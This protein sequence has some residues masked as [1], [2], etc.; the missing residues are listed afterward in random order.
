MDSVLDRIHTPMDLHGLSIFELEFLAKELR[1][2]IIETVSKNGGHLAPNL[3]TIE[4]TLALYSVFSLPEDKVVWDVGHQAY[5]HKILTG[6]RNRFATLRK[7]GGITGF[8]NIRESDY[9]SFGVGHASTSI[10]AALGLAVARDL[11][12][13]D[14]HIIAVIGDGALTGGEAYEALNHAGALKIPLIVIVNDNHMSIDA[15]VGAMNEYLTRIRLAPEYRKAKRDMTSLLRSIPHI[16]DTVY[17]TASHIK[18]GVRAALVAGNLFEE[19]GFHYVGPLDGHNIQTLKE[20]FTQAKESNEPVLLHVCTKKGK[21]YAPAEN[22]PDRF[23]GIGKFNIETGECIPSPSAPKTYTKVFSDALIALAEHDKRIVAITAAMPSGTGLKAFGARYPSRFFD[24]GIAEEHA[25]T[26]AAGM[27]AAGL[28]PVLALYSTF[29]QRAF[30][31]LIHDV[32]LQGLPVTLALDR[33][34]L[35]GE[36][37]PTHHGV[38]DLTYLRMIPNMTI[39]VPKDEEEL[40]YMLGTAI[41]LPSPTAIRYPRGCGLG[42]PLTGD[43]R[44]IPIGKAELLQEGQDVSLLALGTM[45]RAAQQAAGLLASAGISC[46]VVNMRFAKPV[47][48]EEILQSAHKTRCLVTMEENVL[49]GGFG[50]AVLEAL[51]DAKVPV[52]VLR[53]GIPDEFVEQGTRQEQLFAYAMDPEQISE[54]ILH[55]LK[56]TML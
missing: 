56:E 14:G 1:Q 25:M 18:D 22:A 34:G 38:F 54:R 47:D 9:D 20:I 8:P 30:D 40:R 24:T 39:F 33:A 36:D 43:F 49:T 53:I 27:A 44:D 45:V 42:V 7:K 11:L 3:G 31:Q 13:K 46:R 26:L 16:G 29:A 23:H 51:A 4:L 2:L 6:R 48:V 50:S 15:N 5:A 21:G 35:V 19:M 28:H 10:S 17:K 32:C 37:G 41:G 55:F 12:K 52:P